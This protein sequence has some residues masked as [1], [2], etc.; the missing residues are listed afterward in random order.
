MAFL[1]NNNSSKTFFWKKN[2]QIE[3]LKKNFKN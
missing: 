1:K 3:N 2:D